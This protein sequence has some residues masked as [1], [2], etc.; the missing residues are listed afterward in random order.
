MVDDE[1]TGA[2]ESYHRAMGLLETGDSHA[3]A[4]ILE[5]LRSS[6][7]NSQSIL[8]ACARA[9]FDSNRFDSAREAFE[10]LLAI[11]PDNDYAHFGLGLALWR[12]QQFVDARDELAMAFVM[13]PDRPEYATALAQVKATLRARVAEQLPL[14]GDLQ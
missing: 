14:N 10:E 2:Y 1:L 5:E 3:A 11:S 13:R 12:L 7:P 9:L 6:E 8:E 4:I